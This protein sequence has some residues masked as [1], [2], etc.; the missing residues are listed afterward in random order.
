[1]TAKT[2]ATGSPNCDNRLRRAMPWDDG[3]GKD[4]PDG[5]MIHTPSDHLR[6]AREGIR[7]GHSS[8]WMQARQWPD[9]GA[10][11]LLDRPP[12]NAQ[13][14]LNKTALLCTLRYSA[15]GARCVDERV[16]R[17]DF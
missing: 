16:N 7:N 12:H 2:C 14:V 1:M 3:G 11:C 17:D 6:E 15:H 8:S 10:H 5:M 4:G 13:V 9:D